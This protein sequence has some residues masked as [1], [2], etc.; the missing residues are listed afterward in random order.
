MVASTSGDQ[1]IPLYRYIQYLIFMYKHVFWFSCDTQC[2][3][4]C[5]DPDSGC[6]R[7]MVGPRGF[8]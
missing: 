1:F 4:V 8:S 2:A 5:H 3:C 7:A 6:F